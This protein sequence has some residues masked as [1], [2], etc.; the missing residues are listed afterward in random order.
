[1]EKIKVQTGRILSFN[2]HKMPVRGR[3]EKDIS[4]HAFIRL[5]KDYTSNS[6]KVRLEGEKCLFHIKDMEDIKLHDEY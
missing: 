1:M 6:G 5:H 2:Y 4:N 3:V